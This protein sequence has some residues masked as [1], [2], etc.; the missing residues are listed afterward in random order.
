M[1]PGNFEIIPRVAMGD[2]LRFAYQTEGSWIAHFYEIIALTPS[3]G[4]HVR[5]SEVWPHETRPVDSTFSLTKLGEDY[6]IRWAT[7]DQIEKA[8]GNDHQRLVN[9]VNAGKVSD[10]GT[11]KLTW[12]KP[13]KPSMR[14]RKS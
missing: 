8:V 11:E 2:F 10:L 9:L 5:M 3:R 13:Q 4:I 7:I 14:S 6:F 1:K 12:T